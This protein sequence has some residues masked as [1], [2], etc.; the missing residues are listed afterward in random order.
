V[1]GVEKHLFFVHYG[2]CVAYDFAVVLQHAEHRYGPPRDCPRP[3]LLRV[4]VYDEQDDEQVCPWCAKFYHKRRQ[5]SQEEAEGGRVMVMLSRMANSKNP[6]R[7]WRSGHWAKRTVSTWGSRTGCWTYQKA[8]YSRRWAVE[9]IFAWL[10]LC[11]RIAKDRETTIAPS[12]ASATIA[13]IRMLT[14]RA[15][16]YCYTL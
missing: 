6:A 5:V 12:N 10:G 2:Q 3:Q 9:R 7:V 4:R 13:S 11:R 14:R 15:A 8:R 1:S 16:R